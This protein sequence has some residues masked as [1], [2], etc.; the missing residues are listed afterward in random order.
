MT[1]LLVE[2][3][4]E[5][6][7]ARMQKNAANHLQKAIYQGLTD[8]GL[9]IGGDP[10]YNAPLAYYTPRRLVAHIMH[11]PLETEAS[12]EERRGP[13][14]D[15]PEKAL[16]GF[17]RSTG[18]SKEQ[19]I[20]QETAKGN[21]YIANI[22]KPA[23][24]TSDI[25]AQ[26]M[27]QIIQNFPWPKSMRWGTG[28]LR[29]VRPLQNILC[30]FNQK[31]VHFTIDTFK[32]NNITFG[33][34]FMAPEQIIIADFNDYR[35]KLKDAHVILDQEFRIAK[36]IQETQKA[37]EAHGI[38]LVPDSGL[39]QEVT[40]LVE[41]PVP[42]IGTIDAQFQDLPLEL[43]SLTMK[44]HQKYFSGIN[45]ETGKIT[46]F[47]TIANIKTADDGQTILKGNQRVL[48]ARLSD[49][50]F[51][52]QQDLQK[53]LME[54]GK[55]LKTVTYH[56]KLGSQTDRINRI[57]KIASYIAPYVNLD[58]QLVDRA[59][60]LAKCDLTTNIVGEFPELQGVIGK[61]YAQAQNEPQ[62][63]YDAIEQH[64]WPKDASDK[65]PTQPVSI[66]VAL[67]DRL[68]QLCGFWS[69]DEKPTSSKDPYALRRA[70]LGIIKITI[71]NRLNISFKNIINE[72]FEL[73]Y[74]NYKKIN[75]KD[76]IISDLMHFFYVRLLMH[77]EDQG[78]KDGILNTFSIDGLMDAVSLDTDYDFYL[79]KDKAFILNTWITLPDGHSFLE[80]YKRAINILGKQ[81]S[82][83][84]I[85]TQKLH[86]D[87]EKS[88]KKALDDI[89]QKLAK[90]NEFREQ[91]KLL[92]QLAPEITQ[93]FDSVMVNDDDPD[94]RN[95][96]LNLLGLFKTLCHTVCNF[97]KLRG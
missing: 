14:V 76:A 83:S 37:F 69:I 25:I 73:Y 52:Y 47:A 51:F 70:A 15:A 30:I 23:V 81:K 32:S 91:L 60:L 22:Q 97:N 66:A 40:G 44:T 59:V 57:R 54:H 78:I 16:D 67:A 2:L 58:P 63:V 74:D 49:A 61:Y 41:Y 82:F 80:G 75:S 24:Q 85:D 64:Y 26:I 34:R 88:L 9:K 12:T 36:I 96:R 3:F 77:L 6:I 33:H 84:N 56:A 65:V 87:A 43:L 13:R 42:L 29:W 35:Q 79:I 89:G 21:F 95:N 93:F 38:S 55:K 50:Q 46:H 4:S 48:T 39:A 72:N 10:T 17:L 18:L 1:E 62:A 5:E 45:K 90:T 8:A 92:A 7:P 28:A 19:L 71:K 11:I 86:L 27:P 94:I 53:T 31:P 68:E 20:V